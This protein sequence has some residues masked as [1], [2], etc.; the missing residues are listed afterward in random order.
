MNFQLRSQ[1]DN[2]LATFE[3]KIITETENLKDTDNPAYNKNVGS[4]NELN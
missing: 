1:N 2:L 3:I 4:N